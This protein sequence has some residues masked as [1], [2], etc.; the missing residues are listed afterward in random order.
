MVG[1]TATIRSS[2]PKEIMSEQLWRCP[3]CGHEAPASE[4]LEGEVYCD[5][6]GSHTADMCPAEDCDFGADDTWTYVHELRD[7]VWFETQYDTPV[8]DDWK[9]AW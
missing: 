6:C 2:T 1:P 3:E 5:D 4:W 7:G 9:P 8:P